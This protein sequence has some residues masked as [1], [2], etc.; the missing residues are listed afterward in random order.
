[1]TIHKLLEVFNNNKNK[2]IKNK[3]I[4]YF[5]SCQKPPYIIIT[6]SDSRV[7]PA[8]LFN[9]YLGEI[10]V[11]RNISFWVPMY[12]NYLHYPNIASALKYA[13][14]FIGCENII[15]LGHSSCGGLHAR[16]NMNEIPEEIAQWVKNIPEYD[17]V[18]QLPFEKQVLI[19]SYNN[20]LTYPWIK[21]K[22]LDNKVSINAWHFSL[23]DFNIEIYNTSKKIF[24][25]YS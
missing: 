18:L 9:N 2:L 5:S 17:S 8:I 20:L 15:I 21:D 14:D 24:S 3:S 12:E 4:S 10:F 1:M 22:V 11:V 13:V 19:K 25:P 6:C 23:Q 16:K 7:D